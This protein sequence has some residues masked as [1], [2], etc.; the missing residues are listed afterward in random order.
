MSGVELHATRAGQQRYNVRARCASLHANVRAN[1]RT[2]RSARRK[3]LT[4][5]REYVSMHVMDN[6][7]AAVARGEK[8]TPTR[9][10]SRDRSARTAFTGSNMHTAEAFEIAA[11]IGMKVTAHAGFMPAVS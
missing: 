4:F 3:C 10:G 5:T 7:N 9:F 6:S 11:S 2:S 8:G 1:T